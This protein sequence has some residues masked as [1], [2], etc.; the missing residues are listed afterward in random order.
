MIHDALV[1]GGGVM[2]AGTALHLARAGMKVLLLDRKGL[3]SGASGV[4]AGVISL[5][6]EQAALLPYALRG[7]EHWAAAQR[8]LGVDVRYRQSGGVILAFTPEEAAILEARM[9][10]RRAAGVPLEIIP[11]ARAREL[12]P[13]IGPRAV[14]ALHCALDGHA[15]STV[16]GRAWRAALLA[17]GVTLG[18][19]D[20]VVAIERGRDFAVLATSG[21]MHRARRLVLA[22]GAW[23]QP[24]ARMLGVDLPIA[25]RVDT[26][27]VTERMPRLLGRV[28]GHASGLLTLKQ[29]DNGSLL[30]GG[31]RPGRGDA[32]RDETALVPQNL[33]ADLRLAA[34]A[35]PAL[36][37]ARLLGSWHGFE[38]HAPDHLPLAGPLPGVPDA[39]VLACVCGGYTIGPC[40]SE[41][42]ATRILGGE[43]EL[44]L[45]N[46][47]RFGK[48]PAV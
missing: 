3:G 30:I 33:V 10:E 13:A 6:I 19:E 45:F 31:G 22:A 48:A 16:T 41:L 8:L 2:G 38:A 23:T 1:I 15:D 12:E 42:L 26:V 34:T 20:R 40:I 5:Q 24:L 7:R 9:A 14:L 28:I 35:L 4:N 29:A 37:G 21:T 27:S 32:T 47:G 46:P 18:E 25:V 39:W 44:P 36:R 11:A 43:P 17:A